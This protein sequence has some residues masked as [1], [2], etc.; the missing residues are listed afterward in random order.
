MDELNEY[1]QGVTD[2]ISHFVNKG[3]ID[4]DFAISELK[5]L[6]QTYN[7]KKQINEEDML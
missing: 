6:V 3:I 7:L 4:A 2:T 5:Q 1:L